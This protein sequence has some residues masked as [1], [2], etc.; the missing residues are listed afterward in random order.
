MVSRIQTSDK[1]C[2][3]AGHFGTNTHRSLGN[4]IFSEAKLWNRRTDL[5]PDEAKLWNCLR[6]RVSEV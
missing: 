4:E 5:G 1:S 3:I 2:G 6:R